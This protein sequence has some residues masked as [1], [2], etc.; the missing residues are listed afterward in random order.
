[1]SYYD[2]VILFMNIHTM[3]VYGIIYLWFE[4]FPFGKTT[5]NPLLSSLLTISTVFEGIYGFYAIQQA[6]KF[7]C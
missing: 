6:R 4:F 7:R 3:S 5:K 2:P 1:M